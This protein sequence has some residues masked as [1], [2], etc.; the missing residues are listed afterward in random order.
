MTKFFILFHRILGTVLSLLFLVWFLSGFVMIYHGFPN[1]GTKEYRHQTALPDSLP[2]I[3]LIRTKIPET[4]NIRSLSVRVFRE[5]PIFDVK[6]DSANYLFSADTLLSQI[7]E[8]VPF[9]EIETYANRWNNAGINRVDTLRTFDQWIPTG[10]FKKDFPIYK[11]QFADSEKTYLYISS[12]SGKAIQSVNRNQRFWSWLGPI[13]HY[14][15]F[16]QL[17]QHGKE[18]ASVVTWLSG[19]GSLMCLAGIVLGVRSYLIGYR[20][21]KRFRTPYR[22]FYYKWHHILGFFF[23]FFVLM[24]VFSGMM[25]LNDLPQWVVKTHDTD[26]SRKLRKPTDLNLSAFTADYR[27]L[28]KQHKGEIKEISFEQFGEKP[29]YSVIIGEKKQHFDASSSVPTWLYLTESDVLQRLSLVSDAPKS[30]SLITE[31]DDYYVSFSNRTE[32]LPAYKVIANDADKSVFYV[33]PNTGRTVY[34]NKNMRTGKWI[35]PAFHSLRF[36]FFAERPLLRHVVLWILMIGGTIVSFT[37]VALSIKYINRLI[38]KKRRKNFHK[39]C[40]QKS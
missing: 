16:W 21:K 4:Q 40:T 2:E 29:Y 39:E 23:G 32:L 13:P 24:F 37:G 27:S 8:G 20:K 38:R 10:R 36:K 6:T 7:H 22:K 17:R 26:I 12:V 14:I 34:F 15:Y 11:F 3:G 30:I 31:F 9:S 19:I 1:I 5:K 28:L 35:Y 25:S 33:Q 18:W